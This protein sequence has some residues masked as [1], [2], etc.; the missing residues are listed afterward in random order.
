MD[1][2][3]ALA[4]SAKKG[5]TA[6]QIQGAASILQHATPAAA[7]KWPTDKLD[8]ND[9]GVDTAVLSASAMAEILK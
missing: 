7:R 6:A 8:V 5:R 2:H 1:C 4:A 9:D 3:G